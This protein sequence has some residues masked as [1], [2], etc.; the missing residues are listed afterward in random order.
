MNNEFPAVHAATG[1]RAVTVEQWNARPDV[2]IDTAA[3]FYRPENDA[4]DLHCWYVIDG[5]DPHTDDSGLFDIWFASG[6]CLPNVQGLRTIYVS[7]K[8]FEAFHV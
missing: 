4:L 6:A 5:V 2:L 7:A 1:R 3:Y 8:H